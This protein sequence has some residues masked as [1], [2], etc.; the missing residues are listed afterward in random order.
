MSDWA[1]ISQESLPVG[2]HEVTITPDTHTGRQERS[3]VV[4]FAAAS[5]L[6]E[7]RVVKQEGKTAFVEVS[8]IPASGVFDVPSGGGSVMIEGESNAAE[9]VL[10]SSSDPMPVKS[11]ALQ[12]AGTIYPLSGMAEAVVLTGDPGA[13]AQYAFR[14]GLAFGEHLGRSD[15]TWY[16]RVEGDAPELSYPKGSDY[17]RIIHEGAEKFITYQGSLVGITVPANGVLAREFNGESNLMSLSF[18]RGDSSPWARALPMAASI[19]ATGKDSGEV[20]T[21]EVAEAD[22]LYDIPDDPGADEAYAWR[23]AVTRFP[24]NT[25]RVAKSGLWLVGDSSVNQMVVQIRQ[26]SRGSSANLT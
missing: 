22:T 16:G 6:V 13:A 10:D 19:I 25:G 15:R 20:K 12:A 3:A 8:N 7:R 26:A 11:A 18:R 21:V 4:V 1:S 9:L 17:F 24:A 2:D 14:Y 23:L 5:G